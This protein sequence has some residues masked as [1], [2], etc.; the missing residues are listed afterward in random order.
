MVAERENAN[1]ARN[2]FYDNMTK[3]EL[4]D[5]VFSYF[6]TGSKGSGS[7]PLGRRL[8]RTGLGLAAK[9]TTGPKTAGWSVSNTRCSLRLPA[10][11]TYRP[12]PGAPTREIFATSASEQVTDSRV[13]TWLRFPKR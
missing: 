11:G 2:Q 9:A 5:I 3:V 1:G 7:R 6:E 12:D 8:Y 13:S 4:G 10:K